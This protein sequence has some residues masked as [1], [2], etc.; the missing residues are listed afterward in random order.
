MCACHLGEEGEREYGS[1]LW[2]ALLLLSA[3]EGERLALERP[4][5]LQ[6]MSICA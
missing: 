3:G 5:V 4:P 1:S 2:E 6:Q